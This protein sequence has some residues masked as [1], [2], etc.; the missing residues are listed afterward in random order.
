MRLGLFGTASEPRPVPQWALCAF[1]GFGQWPAE[2]V[3][4]QP[5]LHQHRCLT[6]AWAAWQFVKMKVEYAYLAVGLLLCM[7]PDKLEAR[8]LCGAYDWI[9]EQRIRQVNSPIRFTMEPR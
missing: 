5:V 6:N 2:A 3:L 4:G 7:Y 1:F 8:Y 9:D